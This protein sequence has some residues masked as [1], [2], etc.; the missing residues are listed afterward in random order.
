MPEA[1]NSLESLDLSDRVRRLQWFR[2][3][4]HE[5]AETVGRRYHFGYGIDDRLLVDAF[6]RWARAFER[7][8]ADAA[9]NRMDFA[10]YAAG[11]M[12]RH[13]CIVNPVEKIGEGQFDNLMPP[14]PMAKIC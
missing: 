3:S 2:H 1:G 7:E 14:E 6:F 13:L 5:L 12:L 10:V 8:R 4:F 9:R 11:L